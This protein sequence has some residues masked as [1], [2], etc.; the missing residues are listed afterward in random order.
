MQR[1]PGEGD[2]ISRADL[3]AAHGARLA[4]DGDHTVGNDLLGLAAGRREGGKL[5]QR[6]ELDKFRFNR[7]VFNF[8]R[9]SDPDHC[10]ARR[11]TGRTIYT[12]LSLPSAG[13]RMHGLEP[14]FRQTLISSAGAALSAS[15]R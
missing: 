6:V 3:L 10:P 5:Q 14:V 8:S 13:T 9:F 7:N 2:F 4:V 1:V 12:K 11:R 15:D